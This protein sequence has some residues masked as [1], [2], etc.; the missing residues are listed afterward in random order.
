MVTKRFPVQDL[1]GQKRGFTLIELL[2]VIAI[3]AVLIALLLPAVQAAREAARRSQCIN[4]MKQIGIALHNY[5]NA[6]NNFPPG[7]LNARNTATLATYSYG[8]FSAHA[9]LLGYCEQV[10]LFNAA[11]FSIPILS[12]TYGVTANSTVA[13]TRLLMFLCPSDSPPGWLMVNPAAG[14]L[15]QFVAPGC[16]YYASVGSCLE[17]AGQQNAAPPNGPFQYTNVLGR[18]LGI[19]HITDGTSNSIAFG[20]WK[21]GD[22][23]AN[24]YTIPSDII[25]VGSLPNGTARNAGTLIMPNPILVAAF[26]GWLAQCLADFRNSANRSATTSSLGTNW[27]FGIFGYTMGTMLMAPNPKYPNCTGYA[28]TATLEN[29]GM[30]NMA[31]F[32]PGG[33]NVLMCDGSVRFLKDSISQTTIWALGSIAQGEV[34]DANS[35]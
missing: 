21:V 15:T 5:H 10:P 23:D 8:D 12:D 4:N 7:A 11:N 1:T 13:V 25:A 26:P 29:P 28:T 20:E 2:V 30:M 18:S 34:I 3:I 22:G 6:W 35:Y 9:R 32:H 24:T 27:A 16:N 33:A 17:Y 14:V 31:S 19:A